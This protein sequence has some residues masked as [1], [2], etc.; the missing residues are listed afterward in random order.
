MLHAISQ[1]NYPG[2]PHTR[3]LVY[4]INHRSH[5]TKITEV[6]KKSHARSLYVS[7]EIYHG[8]LTLQFPCL[9]GHLPRFK[10]PV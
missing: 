10:C 5:V 9:K 4:Q 1:V 2:V 7:T 6:K 8:K 3:V